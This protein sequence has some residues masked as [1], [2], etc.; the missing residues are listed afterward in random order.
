MKT[1]VA[2]LIV[3]LVC[4]ASPV[5]AGG[6]DVVGTWTLSVE[7]L[8]LRMVLVQ[9]GKRVTGTLQN[10]HGNP[11]AL[12]GEFENGRMR[13]IGSSKGGEWEYNLAGI[14]EFAADG[15]FGGTITSNVGDMKW[16]ATRLTRDR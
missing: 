9:K 3:V 11:I 12:S 5:A 4:A 2:M 8:S 16:T 6:R 15:S 1:A 10:P 7:G 14:G 13:F